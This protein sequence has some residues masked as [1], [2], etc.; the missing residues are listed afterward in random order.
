M[1]IP[2]ISVPSPVAVIFPPKSLF[3]VQKIEHIFYI[4]KNST[5]TLVGE[6]DGPIDLYIQQVFF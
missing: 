3:N 4:A 5:Q 2:A 1:R 6:A